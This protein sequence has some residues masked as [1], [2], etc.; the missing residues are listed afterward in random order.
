MK[1][2]P[3]EHAPDIED[4]IE[5]DQSIKGERSR[6]NKKDDLRYSL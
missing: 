2:R 4:E 5:Q 6:N 1:G 3:P